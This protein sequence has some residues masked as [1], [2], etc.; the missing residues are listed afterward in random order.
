MYYPDVR[1][2]EELWC[3]SQPG[4]VAQ[5]LG[6]E[7]NEDA[8]ALVAADTRPNREHRLPGG[9]SSHTGMKRLQPN[10][11]LNLTSG[12]ARRY[13][14]LKPLDP[15][16][17][18]ACVEEAAPIMAG[19]MESA[20][21]RFPLAIS[22][23]A[24]RDSRLVL[25]AAR[26]IAGRA[27]YV[28]VAK[29]GHAEDVETPARLLPRLGLEHTVIP[30]PSEVSEDFAQVFKQNVS[31]PHEVYIPEAYAVFA[32][33]GLTKVAVT[34]S[35]AELVRPPRRLSRFGEDDDEAITPERLTTQMQMG[36]NKFALDA[37]GAWLATVPRLCSTASR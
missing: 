5:T 34:G 28:T 21:R 10:H 29:P 12:E 9:T 11:Y 22:I 2:T 17:F 32:Y 30:W 24:G 31:L 15:L 14:P 35:A 4:I 16:D 1:R 33:S 19:V 37:L 18:T 25:A 27:S 13:W 6:L 23:T 20:S 3:A 26:Q 36:T 8:L 7:M